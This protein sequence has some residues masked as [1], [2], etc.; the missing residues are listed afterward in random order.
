MT[1]T[2]MCSNFGGFRCLPLLKIVIESPE[3]LTDSDLE[4]NVDVWNRKGD[5]LLCKLSFRL[6][7]HYI[8]IFSLLKYFVKHYQHQ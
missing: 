7:S 4:E 3:K 5:R 8:C 1:A 2:N 6:L